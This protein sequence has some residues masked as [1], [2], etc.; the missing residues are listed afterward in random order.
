[1][2]HSSL[3]L[4]L[5]AGVAISGAAMAQPAPMERPSP[6]FAAMHEAHA[7]QRV[8]DLRTVLRLRPDQEPALQAFLKARADRPGRPERDGPPSAPGALSTPERLDAMARRHEARAAQGQK[9][10]EAVKAFYAALSPEQR[11][12]FDALMRMRGGEMGGHSRMAMMGRHGP[13]GMGPPGMGPDRDGP[14]R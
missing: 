9:R 11:Q 13:P 14:P 2:R 7:R 5:T 3:L 4:A 6:A 12:V 10:A 1:M 8:A